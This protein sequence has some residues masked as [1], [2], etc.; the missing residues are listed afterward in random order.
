[1]S[2]ADEQNKTGGKLRGGSR[3]FMVE[4]LSTRPQQLLGNLPL[5]TLCFL[6]MF[7][8]MS[9]GKMRGN[10][11]VSV[12]KLDFSHLFPSGS[13][14]FP[15]VAVKPTWWVFFF[16]LNRIFGCFWARKH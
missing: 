11:L 16:F 3:V 2:E 10:N 14:L 13:F 6:V 8:S 9:F 15:Q 7:R 4:P 12:G 1:M 5:C